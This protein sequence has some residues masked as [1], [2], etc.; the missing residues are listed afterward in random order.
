MPQIPFSHPGRVIFRFFTF[1]SCSLRE[2]LL[3]RQQ[4]IHFRTSASGL[5]C[6]L[7]AV[8]R[9]WALNSSEKIPVK[10]TYGKC[11]QPAR[12]MLFVFEA[13][14]WSMRRAERARRDFIYKGSTSFWKQN[15][16]HICPCGNCTSG[17]ST[18]LSISLFIRKASFYSYSDVQKWRF[19]RAHLQIASIPRLCKERPYSKADGLR[20]VC[21]N[22]CSQ[23]FKYLHY[24]NTSIIGM[25]T[26]LQHSLSDYKT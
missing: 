11:E 12:H 26:V 15:R 21:N 7:M 19:M 16:K 24:L 22:L 14:M 25:K 4:Q 9:L 23:Y 8:S 20:V 10:E 17:S 2:Q 13:L 1:L 18:E 6:Q 5:C 3:S